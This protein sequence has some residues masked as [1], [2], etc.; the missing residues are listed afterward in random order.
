MDSDIQQR[1]D[2]IHRG[3]AASGGQ[4]ERRSATEAAKPVQIGALHHAFFVDVGAE[5]S[6]AVRLKRAEDLLG[7]EAGRLAPA[8]NDDAAV[9]RIEGDQDAVLAD[10]VAQRSQEG[11]VDGVGG[12]MVLQGHLGRRDARHL[13][14]RVVG[15]GDHEVGEVRG[16]E[17][18]GQAQPD[19]RLPT[20]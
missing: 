3:N 19:P 16:A 20:R 5:E 2:F 13:G 11:L 14:H 18:G 12:E 17:V 10:S 4:F 7:G 9:F 15:V 6:S 1:T 8:F